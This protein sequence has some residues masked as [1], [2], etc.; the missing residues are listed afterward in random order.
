M[1]RLLL[2]ALVLSGPAFAGDCRDDLVSAREGMIEMRG[3]ARTRTVSSREALDLLGQRGERASALQ[4][5]REVEDFWRRKV[6]QT[7]EPQDL[8]VRYRVDGVPGNAGY[9]EHS[10][11]GAQRFPVRLIPKQPRVLCEDSEYRIVSGGFTLNARAA[12]DRAGR[13]LRARCRCRCR[14]TVGPQPPSFLPCSP[15]V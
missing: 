1:L 14:R 11:T 12:G 3:T 5:Q 7:V 13:S 8:I 2:S 10:D 4:F 6:K 15:R 9:A